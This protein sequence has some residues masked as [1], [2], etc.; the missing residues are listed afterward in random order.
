MSNRTCC[1]FMYTENV[2]PRQ[3][4]TIKIYKIYGPRRVRAVKH[5]S[6]AMQ[7]EWQCLATRCG[8]H[9]E[10]AVWWQK[11]AE[12]EWVIWASWIFIFSLLPSRLGPLCA[13]RRWCSTTLFTRQDVHTARRKNMI[14]CWAQAI[15]I[16]GLTVGAHTNHTHTQRRGYG[17]S[18][19]IFQFPNPP[20]FIKK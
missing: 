17:R 15:Y 14:M 8:A 20:T 4:N 5:K 12:M 9:A 1:L 11:K 7:Y 2:K 16:V 10:C 13:S 3:R 19:I 18:E 6:M